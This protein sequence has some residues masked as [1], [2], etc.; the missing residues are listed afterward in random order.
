VTE[1]YGFS[2]LPQFPKSAPPISR[3]RSRPGRR[4][5]IQHHSSGLAARAVA[6]AILFLSSL[7]RKGERSNR[8]VSINRFKKASTQDS[9]RVPNS[10]GPI[11]TSSRTV[12]L[13]AGRSGF[14]R[15]SRSGRASC[16]GF[17][18]TGVA[19][20]YFYRARQGFSRTVQMLDQVVLPA[21]FRP[22]S[23]RHSPD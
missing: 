22:R 14:A 12:V 13:K 6:K 18:P 2:F 7:R 1:D 23:A 15:R 16:P 20:C 17:G 9:S 3:R 5:F 19:A 10:R 21:P 8:G 11:S 4:R